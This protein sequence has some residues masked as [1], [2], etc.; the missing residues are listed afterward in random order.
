MSFGRKLL[1][2]VTYHERV[3]ALLN[4]LYEI[5]DIEI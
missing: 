3:I 4:L 1:D 2:F 5:I